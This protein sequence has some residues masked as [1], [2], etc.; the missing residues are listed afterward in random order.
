M[1][2]QGA[3]RPSPALI[4]ALIALVAALAGTA[5]ALPGKNNVDKNDIKKNAVRSKHIKK[6]AVKSKHVKAGAVKG[7]HLA[8]NSVDGSKIADGS[9]AAADLASQEPFHNVGDPGEPAFSDGGEGDCVWVNGAPP[10]GVPPIGEVQGTHPIGFAK[11]ARGNVWLRGVAYGM[12]GPGGDGFCEPSDPG[13]EED[14]IA[15]T[16]P[17]GYRPSAVQIASG[18]ALIAPDSGVEI[19]GAQLP[20]GSVVVNPDFGGGVLI[21]DNT[22]FRAGS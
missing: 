7:N 18:A 3:R 10:G 6:N 5:T 21:L 15:F 14:A 2:V 9:I 8:A 13:E 19:D 22:V 17:E 20:G 1:G 16:L 4:V 12:G 11:D